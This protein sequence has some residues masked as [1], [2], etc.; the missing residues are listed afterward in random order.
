MDHIAQKFQ[1]RHGVDPRKN[2]FFHQQLKEVCE[3]AKAKLSD[4]RTANLVLSSLPGPDGA[5][6]D[7]ETSVDRE[8]FEEITSDLAQ[9]M[10]LPTKQAIQDA[11]MEIENIDR[12]LLVGGA[13][14][15]PCVQTIA[16]KFFCQDPYLKINPDEVVGLGAAIQAGI[17]TKEIKDVV[18]L[19]VNPL[20]LGVETRGGLVARVIPRNTII[21]ASGTQIFT[22]AKT[23]QTSMDINVLQGE[24]ELAADNIC[25][26]RLDLTG[27]QPQPQ[28]RS[29]VEVDFSI[30]ADG[31]LT[32]AAIDLH[33]D[34]KVSIHIDSAN[35]ISE[36]MISE[37]IIDAEKHFKSD[38]ENK[39][40]IETLIK[41]ENLVTT[42][43]ELIKE[44]HQQLP[45]GLLP[46]LNSLVLDL[47][48]S[49][50]LGDVNDIDAGAGMLT[51][52][53]SDIGIGR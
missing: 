7:F 11:R 4:K 39:K 2:I 48:N 13:T 19:D 3:K 27:I 53:I 50:Q 44:K 17:L 36:S 15:M 14:R 9:M 41:A 34:H 6:I 49:L 42:V 1:I 45:E 16:K 29:R 33:T 18:L 22:T 47:K 23:N 43:D 32:V 26:G 8:T 38:A 51:R 40:K 20:S 35:L 52:F 25:L 24:R 5:L 46:D 28:G 30:D 37:A 12:V 10:I 21:P 31:I